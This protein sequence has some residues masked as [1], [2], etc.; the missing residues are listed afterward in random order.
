MRERKRRDE[1]GREAATM[2][3]MTVFEHTP[4]GTPTRSYR[5]LNS[6]FLFQ[7]KRVV[8]RHNRSLSKQATTAA[9]SLARSGVSGWRV[10][11]SM[12]S[13]AALTVNGALAAI[14]S[15]QRLDAGLKLGLVVNAVDEPHTLGVVDA[16]TAS[17]EHQLLDEGRRGEGQ[18]RAD[19]AGVVAEAELGGRDGELGFAVGDAEVAA[20]G[21]AEAAARQKPWIIATSGFVA[22]RSA[23]KAS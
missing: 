6:G 1:G 17:S 21:D 12:E 13:F 18:Q 11:S 4:Y 14:S 16:E 9:S 15:S 5:P 22:F 10:S 3:A 8:P 23:E 19:P 2:Q 20:G 7:G